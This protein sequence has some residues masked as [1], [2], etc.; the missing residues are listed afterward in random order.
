LAT[1]AH[2]EGAPGRGHLVRLRELRAILSDGYVPEPASG[3]AVRIKPFYQVLSTSLAE[4]VARG[5]V[6]HI[7]AAS[8]ASAPSA[9]GVC[10]RGAGARQDRFY[11]ATGRFAERAAPE[12]RAMTLTPAEGPD[13]Y[14]VTDEAGA[15]CGTLAV[16]DMASSRELRDAFAAPGRDG[17]APAS[18]VWRCF[19]HEFCRWAPLRGGSSEASRGRVRG[20]QAA[21]P[22]QAQP[23]A[24]DVRGRRR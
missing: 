16:P 17:R 23:G 14:E 10:V 19:Y 18:L 15:P 5:C 11:A 9:R 6:G 4:V 3:L 12:G 2:R 1:V 13:L 22:P 24:E 20:L 8:A 7:P 21:A